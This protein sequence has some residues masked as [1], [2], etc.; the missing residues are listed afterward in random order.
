MIRL[1]LRFIG[2]RADYRA[3]KRHRVGRRIA[4]RAGHRA[5]NSWIGR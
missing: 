1:L 3:V 2:F 5:V 4:R